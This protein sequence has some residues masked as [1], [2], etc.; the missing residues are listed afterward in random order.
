[1]NE[2]HPVRNQAY[3]VAVARDESVLF[4]EADTDEQESKISYANRPVNESTNIL[5][6]NSGSDVDSSL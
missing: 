5:R 4:D 1:M 6:E 2:T 3:Q